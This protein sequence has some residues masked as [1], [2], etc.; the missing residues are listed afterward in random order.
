MLENEFLNKL[1]L[2]FLKTLKA[3]YEKLF[4]IVNDFDDGFYE[5]KYNE[6]VLKIKEYLKE[7]I[8]NKNL[9]LIA[10]KMDSA[11]ENSNESFYEIKH[12]IEE[13]FDDNKG[14]FDKL[15][16]FLISQLITIRETMTDDCI[17]REKAMIEFNS[18][19][20]YT[21]IVEDILNKAIKNR[22]PEEGTPQFFIHHINL[23]LKLA[24]KNNKF[25]DMKSCKEY[26]KNLFEKNDF[27]NHINYNK[28][29]LD[30]PIPY[31]SDVINPYETMILYCFESFII[32]LEHVIGGICKD[33]IDFSLRILEKDYNITKGLFD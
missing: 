11:S 25:K 16:I 24:Y 18:F 10:I 4:C 5:L 26:V 1:S 29:H 28:I 9:D 23:S 15:N 30:N 3:Y 14:Y 20:E 13:N 33:Y 31:K 17:T 21:K 2:L 7:N 32:N 27:V 12:K 22:N 19:L 8:K 6:Q